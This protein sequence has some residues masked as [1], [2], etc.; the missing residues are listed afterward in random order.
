MKLRLTSIIGWTCTILV[1]ALNIF[2][3]VMKFVPVAPGSPQDVM[4]Q[5][6]GM[7]GLLH[8]LGVLELIIVVLFLVPRTS[9]VGFVLMVGY[10]GGVLATLLTHAQD[11]TMASVALLLIAISGWFRNRELT[12]RLLGKT[13]QVF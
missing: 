3:A 7:N 10:F 6:T 5:Q 12:A 1:A 8:P 9:T 4:M 2:A 11:P 13:A